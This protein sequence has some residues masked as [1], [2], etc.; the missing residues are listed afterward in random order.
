MKALE[1]IKFNVFAFAR[2]T[3]I[4]KSILFIHA[5]AVDCQMSAKDRILPVGRW[6]TTKLCR[7][8][9]EELA[10]KPPAFS[11][12]LEFKDIGLRKYYE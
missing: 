12:R 7:Q 3:T 8:N 10:A 4:A 6:M 1:Y 2:L 11:K 5:T 9:L